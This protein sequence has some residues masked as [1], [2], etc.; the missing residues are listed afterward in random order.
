M[1]LWNGPP[2]SD[3]LGWPIGK[4]KVSDLGAWSAFRVPGGGLEPSPSRE[5]YHFHPGDPVYA[6]LHDRFDWDIF[7]IKKGKL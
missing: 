2:A 3:R 6:L 4:P 1:E 7:L 5:H